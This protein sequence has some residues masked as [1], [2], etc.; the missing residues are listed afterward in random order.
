MIECI[1]ALRGQPRN[2]A[3]EAIY[4]VSHELTTRSP[5]LLKSDAPNK[6]LSPHQS[7]VAGQVAQE[8]I[9]II[10]ARTVKPIH[11][12]SKREKAVLT[13]KL[14]GYLKEM[15]SHGDDVKRKASSVLKEFR[16][17]SL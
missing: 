1:S 5:S 12:L 16:T 7:E 2:V 3:I 9:N 11:D 15:T 6:A 17:A 8:M 10:E 13:D 14:Y 4:R